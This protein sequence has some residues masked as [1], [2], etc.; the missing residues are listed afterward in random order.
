MNIVF[1]VHEDQANRLKRENLR[2]V[3]LGFD[4]K[5]LTVSANKVC[6]LLEWCFIVS[7]DTIWHWFQRTYVL[8]TARKNL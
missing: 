3:R 1:S 6:S 5:N 8:T 2:A 4:S 7:I